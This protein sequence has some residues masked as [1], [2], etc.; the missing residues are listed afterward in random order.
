[1]VI[2]FFSEKVIKFV[3]THFGYGF[4][5]DFCQIQFKFFAKKREIPQL[6]SNNKKVKKTESTSNFEVG[7]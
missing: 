2:V 7:F 3:E 4:S 5:F 6:N 1:M